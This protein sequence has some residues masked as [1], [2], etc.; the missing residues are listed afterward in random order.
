AHALLGLTRCRCSLHGRR[1]GLP[2][3]RET[4]PYRPRRSID[5]PA[6]GGRARSTAGPPA[7]GEVIGAYIVD[8]KATEMIQELVNLREA[9]RSSLVSLTDIPPCPRRSSKPPAPPTDGSF[10][11]S[12]SRTAPVIR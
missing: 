5:T 11:A 7:T 12:R 8:T 6:I 1:G 2:S 4:I 9:T 10:M 3:Q